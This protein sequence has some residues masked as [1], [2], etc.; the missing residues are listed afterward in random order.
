M[1]ERTVLEWTYQPT[2]YF[3][4]SYSHSTLECII[5]IADGKVTATL[6]V[7]QDPVKP[8]LLRVVEARVETIFSARQLLTHQP[9]GLTGPTT[10]QHHASG[11]MDVSISLDVAEVL[12]LCEKIDVVKKSPSGKIIQDTRAERIAEHTRFVNLMVQ[13]RSDPLLQ[14]LLHSYSAAV[15]DPA[16]ELVHLYEIRDALAKRLDGKH[17]ALKHL[18]IPESEWQRLGFLADEAPLKQGRHRG[19]HL[20]SL[21]DATQGELDEARQIV[22]GWIEKYALSLP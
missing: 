3:E 18:G 9:Y 15:N 11:R 4:A 22:H 8:D 19:K 16:N 14:F 20:G 13:K 10:Y 5:A 12:M 7:P 6:V 17:T 2:T 1:I 21:R